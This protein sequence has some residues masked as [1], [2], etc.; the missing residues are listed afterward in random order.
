LVRS[1][2]HKLI[3]Y[4]KL[5]RYQLFDLVKDPYEITNQFKNPVYKQVKIELMQALSH[6]RK[7]L[8]DGLLA[9]K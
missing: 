6:K 3:F 1:K 2:T 4:P 8:G 9:T 5:K 7:E